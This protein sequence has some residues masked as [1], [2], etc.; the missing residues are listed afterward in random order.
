MITLKNLTTNTEHIVK[1][2]IF[3]D[4]TSQVWKLPVEILDDGRCRIIWHFE[5][6]AELFHLIQLRALLKVPC[7]A[8][9]VI[10]YLPYGR[11]DKPVN[12]D[13]TFAL[14]CFIGILQRYQWSSITTF[15]AHSNAVESDIV[16]LKVDEQIE[17]AMVASNCNLVCF[18]DAG[19]TKRG[20]S[21]TFGGYED[22]KTPSFNLDKKR[23]QTTGAIE[24]LVCSLPLDLRDKTILLCDDICDGGETFKK[25]AKLLYEM[26]AKHVDL[27]VT[28][29]IFSKGVHL[30]TEIGKIRNIYTTDSILRNVELAEKHQNLTV[31]KLEL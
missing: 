6:E 7:H 8:D 21:L 29:G 22:L 13:S 2:T 14:K 5:N 3:P 31:F 24:G 19:A 15:D 1:P 23:N 9:L 16:S 25:A 27:Y 28:H 10:P 17:Q 12:N 4:G 26:G 30:L 20:Y 11:Q 18:P